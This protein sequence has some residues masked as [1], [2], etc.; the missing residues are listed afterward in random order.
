VRVDR[1]LKR[2]NLFLVRVWTEQSDDGS[3]KS[4]LHGRVQRVVDGES[5]RFSDWQGLLD[6]LETMLSPSGQPGTS[7]E[8]TE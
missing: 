8:S 5:H 2:T 4:E 6:S 1:N 3:R 7:V